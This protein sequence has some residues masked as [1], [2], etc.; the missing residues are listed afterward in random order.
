M[1]NKC[2][3]H[4]CKTGYASEENKE[5]NTI[6]ATFHFPSETKY[7]ELRAKWIR[8]VNRKDFTTASASNVLCEKHFEEKFISRGGKCR[9]KMA[10]DPMPSIYSAES[11]KRPSC[12]PLPDP[13]PRKLPKQRGILPDELQEF[14][15]QDIIHD[16]SE[17][18]EEHAPPGFQ[19]RKSSD[20][21]VYYRMEFDKKT[22]F[23]ALFESIRIDDE[24]HVQLQ[25]NG[26]RVPLPNWF[27]VGRNA[28]LNRKSMISNFPPY[29][30]KVA[31]D[32][33]NED[34]SMSIMDELEQRKHMQPKGRPPYSAAVIRY[35]LLLRYTSAQAYRQLLKEFPLPS[36]S[37]LSKIQR[38]GVDSI[39]ALKC[40]REKGKISEDL[41]LMA[42]EMYLQKA[43]EWEGGEY[44]GENEDGVLYKGIV[45]FMAVGVK[46]NTPYVIKASPEVTINGSWLAKEIDGC[47]TL[48]AESGFRV[49]AV[50]TDNHS[51]NVN[52]FK[53]MKKKYNSCDGYSVKHPKN[54][55]KN[56][57]LFY[58]N[59]HLLKNI[60]NN[61]L[62]NK[63]FVFPSFNIDL[64][65]K[66][67]SSPDGY[68]S[69]ADFHR[70]HEKDAE[71]DANLR[72]AP[73][74]TYSVLHPGN[75][76]QDVQRALAVIHD[77]TIAAFKS[78]F[79]GRKDC[80]GVL[81][82]FNTW[83]LIVN[84]KERFH[85]N[86]IGDAVK[87]DDGKVQ[88]LRKFADWLEEWNKSPMF[89]LTPQTFSA[90]VLKLFLWKSSSVKVTNT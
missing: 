53:E 76:K 9:L 59:V 44:I 33:S 74:L 41:V 1:V 68:I 29:L 12:L 36:F 65:T 72:K 43:S 45:T 25:Y 51:S 70:V 39:K 61:L 38:G 82:L 50:V 19:T 87:S 8:W 58:D 88:F 2:V 90:C 69:W 66:N 23:P 20:C 75:N 22:N 7:P 11:L 13:P 14:N 42:D 54:H 17:L 24:L 34:G 57:F 71:L 46:T 32:K 77:T 60:R 6:I 79:P 5:N 18:R 37:L 78:F 84:S 49:R 81:S 56:T 80:A 26:I 67:I 62:A 35:A 30:Q 55:G 89:T 47:I 27:V 4:G 85:V 83:W 10:M 15:K 73:K 48:L 21:I 52:A 31:V 63:K 16:L 40:L 3:A 86:S 64:G 28:K